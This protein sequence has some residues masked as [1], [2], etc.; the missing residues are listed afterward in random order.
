MPGGGGTALSDATP[1]ALGTAAAGVSTSASRADHV[2]EAPAA[3]AA[4]T[5][6]YAAIGSAAT[7]SGG[8]YEVTSGAGTG[9]VYVSDGTAWKLI[10]S[11]REY[12]DDAPPLL[13]RLDETS[14]TYASS[15][16][17]AIALTV[18]G[19]LLRES[20]GYDGRTCPRFTGAAGIYAASPSAIAGVGLGI[21]N[22]PTALTL[23]AWI[24]PAAGNAL[25]S[26][27]VCQYN[28]AN[29]NPYYTGLAT[30]A[31]EIRALLIKAGAYQEVKSGS[32]S[33]VAVT[34]DWQ[35]VG[36]TYDGAGDKKVRFY[37]NGELVA[38]SSAT[39]GAAALDL[40]TTSR[41][42]VGD[43]PG[44]ASEYYAGQIASARAYE[45]VQPLS[46][47]RDVYRRGIGLYRGQ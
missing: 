33:H 13:W 3:T 18:T 5:G 26:I 10:H 30:Y 9:D 42:V 43:L 22:A 40:G 17:E 38:T 39:T 7:Y 6:T 36:W 27:L 24:K 12:A 28:S 47:W 19:A 37:V 21:S 8:V 20:I 1:A 29:V 4:R 14:S 15:G 46:W 23:A 45:A 25:R 44:S 2:H 34:Y 31:G 35:H 41:W 16:S 32:A 11:S